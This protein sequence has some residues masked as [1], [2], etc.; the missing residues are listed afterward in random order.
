MIDKGFSCGLLQLVCFILI[1]RVYLYSLFVIL[2]WLKANLF[3]SHA[4]T[5]VTYGKPHMPSS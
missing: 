4:H 1:S 3:P 2:L 5:D